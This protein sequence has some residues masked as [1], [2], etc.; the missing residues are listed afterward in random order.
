MGGVDLSVLRASANTSGRAGVTPAGRAFQKHL[1]R[2]RAITGEATG[3]TARHAAQGAQLI[4]RILNDQH[5]VFM[6][7]PHV[8]HGQVLEVRLPGGIG[9]RWTADGRRFIGFLKPEKGTLEPCHNTRRNGLHS[10]ATIP[11]RTM[12]S[13]WRYRMVTTSWPLCAVETD[14]LWWTFTVRP[15]LPRYL[16]NG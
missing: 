13:P 6:V 12:P 11:T 1:A 3:S 9:A 2:G 10:S 4:E 16:W 15:H 8:V 7:R 14:A 5:A